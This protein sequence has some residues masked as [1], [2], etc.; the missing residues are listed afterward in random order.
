MR[1]MKDTRYH[2]PRYAD[3]VQ[4]QLRPEAHAR[5]VAWKW[6][7]T[8]A[9]ERRNRALSEAFNR[10]RPR[11]FG[12]IFAGFINFLGLVMIAVGAGVV[13]VT[14]GGPEAIVAL[15][16]RGLHMAESELA[17]IDLQDVQSWGPYAGAAL[18]G[19]WVLYRVRRVFYLLGVALLIGLFALGVVGS[20]A[21]AHQFASRMLG[22]P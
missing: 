13:L 10:S 2:D 8:T 18:V 7:M 17:K 6:A 20:M 22:G 21:L 12:P 16:E 3:E 4:R 5:R 11:D 9:D 1:D 19:T 15:A 14:I